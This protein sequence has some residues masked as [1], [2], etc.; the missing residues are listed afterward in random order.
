MSETDFLK[1]YPALVDRLRSALGDVSAF[2]A[3]V[4]GDFV[5]VGY[6]ESSLLSSI[7][8]TGTESVVDVGCGS[9]RLA[10]PLSSFPNLTYIG[11][12]IVPELIQYARNLT[13]RPDWHFELTDG[14]KIPCKDESVDFVCFFSVF[15]H[16]THED[17]FKYLREA[18]RVLK[19]GGRIVF[20]FLEFEIDS[21]WAVFALSV[22]LG[23]PGDHHNQFIERPAIRAWVKQLGLSI[24]SIFDGDKPHIPI[25][26]S[27]VWHDGRVMSGFGA[28][29]QSVAIISK[30]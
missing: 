20:S 18:K 7:G 5:T 9:G 6:L 26:E 28:L 23:N 16:I 15:T 27:V 11:T 22:D 8:L 1:T 13:R 24:E 29:G 4:G 21:H 25:A 17:S 12:D 14:T 2:E 10:L 19:R 3:A 30:P